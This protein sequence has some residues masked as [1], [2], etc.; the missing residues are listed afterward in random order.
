MAT[1]DY[2]DGFKFTEASATQGPFAI[3]GGLYAFMAGASW[4]D[5]G[6]VT[7]QI[8]MPDG[9]TYVDVHEPFAADGYTT[10]DLPAGTVQ[11]AI[12]TASSV[13][14]ALLPVRRR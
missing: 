12:E 2:R 4:N 14:A 9:T 5:S 6:T 11:V 7:L 10:F 13:Q 1:K 8:L 3:L